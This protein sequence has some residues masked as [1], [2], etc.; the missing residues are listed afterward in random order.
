MPSHSV[1]EEPDL[2]FHP[3]R[4]QDRHAH[5][6]LGL[7]EHGPFSRSLVNTVFEPTRI[8]SIYP[9]GFRERTRGFFGQTYDF[10]LHDYIKAVNAARGVP[11]QIVLENSA[12]QYSCRASVM[13]RLGIALYCKAGGVPWKLADQDPETAYIGLSYAVRAMTD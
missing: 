2:L 8:A 3:D 9:A 7:L 5:P 1:V 11:T 6:L 13:W 12:L 10:N 4:P